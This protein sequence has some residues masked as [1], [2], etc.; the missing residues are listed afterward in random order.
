MRT[1]EKFPPN[2][3]IYANFLFQLFVDVLVEKIHGIIVTVNNNSPYGLKI[4]P[5]E[6]KSYLRDWEIRHC[7]CWHYKRKRYSII[8]TF[9][10]TCDPNTRWWTT[11][12]RRWPRPMM[13]S[14]TSQLLIMILTLP[15]SNMSKF[16][17]RLEIND[18][19]WKVQNSS[20][21]KRGDETSSSFL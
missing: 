14:K 6:G 16:V 17:R 21:P 12:S 13:P 15:S 20:S 1:Q 7:C 3:F 2:L 11:T 9:G 10:D 5:N 19:M 18:K 4:S 8:Y